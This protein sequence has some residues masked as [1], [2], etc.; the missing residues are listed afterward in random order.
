MKEW[1]LEAPNQANRRLIGDT[2]SEA[3]VNN[4]RQITATHPLGGAPGYHLDR[5]HVR[6]A[7]GILGGKGGVEVVIQHRSLNHEG[8]LPCGDV[9]TATV[10]IYARPE[11]CPEPFDL[12]LGARDEG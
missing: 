10:W 6:Y 7:R 4:W 8:T 5:V 1:T 2:L 11:D 3:I 12:E 9:R